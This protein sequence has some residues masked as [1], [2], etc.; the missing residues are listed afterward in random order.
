MY[1]PISRIGGGDLACV[2]N[3]VVVGHGNATTGLSRDTA[4]IGDG[5]G[6][7]GIYA[8]GKVA[9]VVLG[10]DRAVVG[11]FTIVVDVNAS[12]NLAAGGDI[13]VVDNPVVGGADFGV[14]TIRLVR[15]GGD[16][17]GLGDGQVIIAVKHAARRAVG[18]GCRSANG[19]ILG[20]GL[21]PG[22]KHLR[23]QQQGRGTKWHGMD[24]LGHWGLSSASG[25]PA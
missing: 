6:I 10:G 8:R 9:K 22:G 17:T 12:R 23:G 19:K 4:I 11:D 18:D 20:P 13:A 3:G 14:N 21:K 16:G 25:K 15:R 24:G 2:G 7:A 1:R 5:V